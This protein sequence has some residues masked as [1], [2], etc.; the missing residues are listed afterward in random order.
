MA[1]PRSKGSVTFPEASSGVS[2]G[3]SRRTVANL[4]VRVPVVVPD[5]EDDQDDRAF[6]QFREVFPDRRVVQVPALDIVV[7]G[8]GIHCIT[9]QQP[10]VA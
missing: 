8:G 9:Q 3:P 2:P 7:G 1:S 6:R 5:F 4:P 10:S